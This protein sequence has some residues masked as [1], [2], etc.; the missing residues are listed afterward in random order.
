MI[1]HFR[2]F[3]EISLYAGISCGV[4]FLVRLNPALFYPILILRIGILLYCWFVIAEVERNRVF[5]LILGAAVLIGWVGGYWDY[6]ELYFH[7][8][9]S[10]IIGTATALLVFVVVV[11]S[12][13]IHW[14]NG[15]TIQR[16]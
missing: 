9:L 12:I 11:C 3:V 14:N 6:F 5:G 15:T 13:W 1:R 16:R 8:N 4:A 7:Y 2:N 10:E